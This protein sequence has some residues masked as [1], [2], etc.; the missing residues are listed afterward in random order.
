ML[1]QR[2]VA[3]EQTCPPRHNFTKRLETLSIERDGTPTSASTS[4]ERLAEDDRLGCVGD[5]NSTFSFNSLPLPLQLTSK[6]IP[7]R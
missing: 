5:W 1:G 3:V 2:L 4:L 7:E 6:R